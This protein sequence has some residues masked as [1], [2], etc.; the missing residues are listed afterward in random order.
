MLCICDFNENGA[1]ACVAVL[2]VIYAIYAF[3]N[4]FRIV[5]FILTLSGPPA[6]PLVGNAYLATDKTLLQQMSHTAYDMYGPIFRIWLTVFPAVVLFEPADIQVI[7]SSSKHLEK[8][9]FYRMLHNFVGDGLITSEGDRWKIH[10]KILQPAFHLNILDRFTDTFAECAN[11]LVQGI[12]NSGEKNVNLTKFVN[13]AVIDILNET[14]LGVTLVSKKQMQMEEEESPFRK[15]QVVAPYR[16]VHPWLL[17]NWIYEMTA[18]GQRENA[19]RAELFMTCKKMIA[20]KREVIRKTKSK[21]ISEVDDPQRKTSMLEFMVE[22]SE[23]NP[24]FTEDD[25]VNECCTFMLAGQDSVG[26]AVAITMFL[27]ATHHEWQQKC[28]QELEDIFEADSRSP[29][30]KDLREMRCLEMCIKESL[31]LYPSVPTFARKLGEDTKVGNYVI[32]AGCDVFVAPYATHRLPHHYPDPHTF[33]PTRF[34]PDN[35]EKR[36]PYAFFPFS[37]GPRNCIGYKFAM[38]EMKALI[39][40]VLRNFHLS[41]IPGK[42]EVR[43]K[44]RLTL[45]AQGGL[46]V[47]FRPRY[48]NL[49]EN[50]YV[51]M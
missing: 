31:R 9:Y 45:R 2:V 30:M 51:S 28:V 29:T 21:I 23:K 10:R 42:E 1:W 26:S 25:I 24:S 43:P 11:H 39:S 38:L 8:T 41:P 44:F 4:Y 13:D 36:H 47:N 7:L 35:S 37:A 12:I 48:S 34:D 16:M 50:L 18:T 14:I 40:A 20:E 33:D 6:L 3:R 5:R 15:G 49:V 17:V 32:P 19:H 27:L 46:W 22:V